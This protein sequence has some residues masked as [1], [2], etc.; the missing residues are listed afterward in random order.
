MATQEGERK[1][2]RNDVRR[3]GVSR[4]IR[5]LEKSGAMPFHKGEGRWAAWEG[6]EVMKR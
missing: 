6:Q 3:R 2:R 5:S 1:R 4:R